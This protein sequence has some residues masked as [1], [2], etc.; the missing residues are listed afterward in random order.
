MDSAILFR[1]VFLGLIIAVIVFE[2]AG[3]ILFKEDLSFV[4]KIGISLGIISLVLIE[5]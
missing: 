5:I 4:N 1:L 3:V 2:V